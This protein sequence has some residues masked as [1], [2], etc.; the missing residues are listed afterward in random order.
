[1]KTVYV[2]V[3]DTMADWEVGYATAE[4]NS[5]RYLKS[6]EW[7]VVV[8]AATKDPITTMGGMTIKPGASIAEVTPDNA[9]ML[10]LPGA[11]TWFKPGHAPLIEKVK[12]LL[13]NDVP[14]A[15]I[16]GATGALAEAGILDDKKHTSNGLPYLKMFCPHYNGEQNYQ[17]EL[18]VV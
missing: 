12:A 3:L 1:M 10:I 4:L 17:D 9:S 15:A 6:K 5:G 13:K 11:D 14:V 8:C 16:C 7:Q 2:Y 18:V